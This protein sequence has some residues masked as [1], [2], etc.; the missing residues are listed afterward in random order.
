M[1]FGQVAQRMHKD[2]RAPKGVQQYEMKCGE[3][4]K[5]PP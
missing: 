5:V 3:S 1:F 2:F 4:N